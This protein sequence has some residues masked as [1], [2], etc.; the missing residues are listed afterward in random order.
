MTKKVKKEILVLLK[1]THRHLGKS[2]TLVHVKSGYA[3]NYLVPSNICELSTSQTLKLI[4]K[5]Q[6]DMNLREK[7][8]LELSLKNKM[9]LEKNHPYILTKRVSDDN[10]I[11]GKVTLKQVKALIESQTNLDLKEI[12]VELPEIKE[13]GNFPITLI[14]HPKIKTQINIEVIAQ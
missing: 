12:L 1:Q 14:L 8:N 10:K 11:F 3:R 7:Q 5:K 13:I 9:V 6:K 2:G 4:E